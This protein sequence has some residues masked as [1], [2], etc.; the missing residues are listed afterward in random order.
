[1]IL[2]LKLRGN[3]RVSFEVYDTKQMCISSDAQRLKEVMKM[4]PSISEIDVTNPLYDDRVES[5]F[6]FLGN[7]RDQPLIQ[8]ETSYFLGGALFCFP[9]N[10]RTAFDLLLNSEHPGL[11]QEAEQILLLLLSY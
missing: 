3:V 10:Y 5:I 4:L 1:M 7:I 11:F 2:L 6:T 8:I 9:F